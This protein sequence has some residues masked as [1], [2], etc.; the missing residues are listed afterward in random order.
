VLHERFEPEIQTT[1]TGMQNPERFIKS[2][3]DYRLATFRCCDR[4]L[5]SERRFPRSRRTGKERARAAR[6]PAA[7]EIVEAFDPTGD[8]LVREIAVMFGRDEAGE[9]AQPAAFD[10]EVMIAAAIRRAA[11]FADV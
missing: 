4:E 6:H 5:Q 9:D 2:V 1:G 3:N 8:V 10:D 7:E 11:H